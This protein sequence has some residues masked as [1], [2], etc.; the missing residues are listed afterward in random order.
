M[1]TLALASALILFPLVSSAQEHPTDPKWNAWLGCWELAVESARDGSTRPSPSRRTLQQSST[2]SRPQICVAPSG[3]G[4][5]LTTLVANQA[6]IEQTIVADGADHSITD[7]ECRGTQRAEWSSDGRKVYSRA[8]LSCPADKG[9]VAC[10]AS[11][12]ASGTWTD[13]ALMSAGSRQFARSYRRLSK[14]HRLIRLTHAAHS[15]RE[16][17]SSKV[18]HAR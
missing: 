15:R 5:T 9:T 13:V 4:V 12:G 16:G 1:K 3:N 17:R 6:A 2:A 7:A 11:L 14:P 10:R 18:S 8:D